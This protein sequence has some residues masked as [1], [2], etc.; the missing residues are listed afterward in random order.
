MFT[1]KHGANGHLLSIHCLTRQQWPCPD[2]ELHG[3]NKLFASKSNAKAHSNTHH[4]KKW[5]CPESVKWGC[6]ILFSTYGHAQTHLLSVHFYRDNDNLTKQQW[7][8]PESAKWGC[9]AVYS[10]QDH[11]EWHF[12][13]HH[14]HQNYNNSPKQ[15]W[16][17]PEAEQYSCDK[18][19]KYQKKRLLDDSKLLK[20]QEQRMR[21][22]P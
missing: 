21:V 7:P 2:A 6:S 17:C 20:E 12:L 13:S 10:S 1:S 14:C 9:S 16:P 11:A 22:S 19:K 15:R 8:C 4:P 5:P 18:H 3:C